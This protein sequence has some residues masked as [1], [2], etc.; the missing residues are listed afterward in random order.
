MVVLAVLGAVLSMLVVAFAVNTGVNEPVIVKQPYYAYLKYVDFIVLTRNVVLEP[1]SSLTISAPLPPGKGYEFAYMILSISPPSPALAF[2]GG[3]LFFERTEIGA[4]AKVY[5]RSERVVITN[6]GPSEVRF[7]LTITYVFEKRQFIPLNGDSIKIVLPDETASFVD[8]QEV[9]LKIPNYAPFE[10]VDVVFPNGSR[11]SDLASIMSSSINAVKVEPKAVSIDASELPKGVYKIVIRQG[12]EY[13]MPSV[14][15]VKGAE[16]LNF[17]IQPGET[18]RITG[19]EF[20]V[21]K[22]WRLLGYVVMVYGVQPSLIGSQG[23]ILIKANRIS[24]I[25]T[26][27]STIEITSVTYLIPPIMRL[28]PV[29]G[30]YLIYDRKFS[31][32]NRMGVPLITM[33]I[34]I[35]YKGVG[36]WVKGNVIIDVTNEDV[37]TGIWTSIVIQLPP[38]AYIKK[39][40]TPRGAVYTNFVNSKVP[41]GSTFRYVSISPDGSQAYIV[42]SM[43]GVSET[44]RYVIDVVWR[45]IRIYVHDTNGKPIRGVNVELV[46]GDR[47]VMSSYTNESGIALLYV[48]MPRPY[49]IYVKYNGV[50]TH[51][52]ELNSLVR[53]YIDVTIGLYNVTVVFVGMRN[54][55]I[56]GAK[57]VLHRIGDNYT[58]TAVTDESGIASFT[59]VIAGRYIVSCKYGGSSYEKV[60]DVQGNE[61]VTVK[62]DIMAI[63]GGI[64]LTTKE[65]LIIGGALFALAGAIALWKRRDRKRY[66]EVE[67]I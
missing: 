50:M 26:F 67:T 11:F 14:M 4:V 35:I 63:V 65:L 18:L 28:T 54:Q 30:A 38:L 34:P 5:A 40:I 58:L 39:I 44:G 7:K 62:S 49:E 3:E 42:V 48:D 41:W 56:S 13:V 12:E 27:K 51:V 9:V 10:I 24:P 53:D 36:R 47:V 37:A 8:R 1:S 16:M 22:G 57:V 2:S 23:L 20:G 31:I 19:S 33:V 59:N 32:E 21:P 60:I 15:L 6:T 66:Y 17:T 25:S 61:V 52:I 64:P 46:A 29:F 45:P 55:A 43:S